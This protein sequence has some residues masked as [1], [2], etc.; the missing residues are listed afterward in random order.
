MVYLLGLLSAFTFAFGL[1]L[2]QRG[3]LKTDAPEGDARFLGQ[4]LRKPVWLLGCLMLFGGWVF[5]A[6]ALDHGSLAL[7]QSLQALS[8]VLALPLGHWL[9]AQR[10]GI[11]Q[12]GGACMTVAGI[13]LL[14]TLGQPRGG[15]DTP[16]AAA[17]FVAGGVILVLIAG[18]V[19]TAWRRRGPTSA[20]LF[21]AAAGLAFAFQAASTKMLVIQFEHGF[22]SIFL[23][24]PLYAFILAELLG[25]TLQQA[26]L[27]PGFLAAATGALNAATLIMSVI[28]GIGVFRE[29]LSPEPGRL[30]PALLG[31]VVAVIGV[32]VLAS[33]SDP[34]P[35]PLGQR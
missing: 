23:H 21:G 15:T 26:A 29:S 13:V 19:L 34:E 9:T 14:T 31:L 5:Q 22:G 32:I 35:H 30:I 33:S 16:A 17:W 20:V 24:W 27:K 1:A 6:A 8:L 18:L 25:F 12:T 10:I 3:T 28:L 11:R 7:V 2:Q 4:V